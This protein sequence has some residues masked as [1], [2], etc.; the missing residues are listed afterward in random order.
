MK[1]LGKRIKDFT[2]I[3]FKEYSKEAQNGNL[4]FT[5][6]PTAFTF[7]MMDKMIE[8]FSSVGELL[9]LSENDGLSYLRNS[10]YILLRGCLAKT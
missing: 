8:N 2:Q 3:Y 6:E 1:G 10:V 9:K 5:D 7:Y 4:K